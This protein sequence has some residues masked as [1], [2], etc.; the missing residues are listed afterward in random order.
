VNVIVGG[1]GWGVCMDKSEKSRTLVRA[2]NRRIR[3]S[4]GQGITEYGAMLAFVSI[5]IACVFGISGS[6]KGGVTNAYSSMAGQL[7]NLSSASASS[8]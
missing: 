5:L 3:N 2:R 4:K 1:A 7:N 6:L 8:S